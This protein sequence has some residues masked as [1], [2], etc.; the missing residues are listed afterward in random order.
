MDEKTG[1]PGVVILVDFPPRAG[2]AAKVALLSAEQVA[3]KSAHAVDRAMET[4]RGMAERVATTVKN[5][6]EKPQAVEVAFG[7]K[8]DAEAGALI[9]KTGV[10]ATI[11]VKIT[12]KN[13]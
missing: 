7:L 12:W 8:L 11:N 6:T 2:T 5:I 9:A 13:S 3:E 4:I 10:E 1:G